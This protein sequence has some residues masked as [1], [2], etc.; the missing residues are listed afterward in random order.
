[1]PVV[2]YAERG[3]VFL[4]GGCASPKAHGIGV[5]SLS[6]HTCVDL[7]VVV[8]HADV[9]AHESVFE[10]DF[11]AD[12][13]LGEVEVGVAVIGDNLVHPN[14]PGR[15]LGEAVHRTP[16]PRAICL[17]EKFYVALKS[18]LLTTFYFDI[19]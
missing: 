2:L 18:L 13:A 17:R 9:A 5:A 11:A 16:L 14:T 10:V 7:V 12:F 6:A 1:M 19:Y 4:R 15:Y 8:S 3:E